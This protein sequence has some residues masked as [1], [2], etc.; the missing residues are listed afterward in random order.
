MQIL[1]KQN[2]IHQ[3]IAEYISAKTQFKIKDSD[4]R[5]VEDWDGSYGNDSQIIGFHAEIEIGQ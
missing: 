3:A 1:L 5:I 4:V 2:E